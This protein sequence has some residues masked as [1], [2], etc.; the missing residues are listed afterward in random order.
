M[1]DGAVRQDNPV[2]AANHVEHLIKKEVAMEQGRG[3]M[4]TASHHTVALGG[5]PGRHGCDNGYPNTAQ[6]VKVGGRRVRQMFNGGGDAAVTLSTTDE[7][8]P[9]NMAKFQFR[10][11]CV[12]T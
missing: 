3:G 8:V 12:L 4:G 2:A 11:M 1:S 7:V 5:S 10:G 9:P 6:A